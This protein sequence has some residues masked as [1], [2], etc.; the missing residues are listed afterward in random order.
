MRTYLQIFYQVR[1]TEHPVPKSNILPR[2][3]HFLT[4]KNSGSGHPPFSLHPGPHSVSS[5]GLESP[6]RGNVGSNATA[7]QACGTFDSKNRRCTARDGDENQLVACRER[8]KLL[9]G[10]A[11]FSAAVA[12]IGIIGRTAVVKAIA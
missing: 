11:L 5:E 7:N 6:A 4:S 9:Q 3:A 12:L 10:R 2:G 1:S 8:L